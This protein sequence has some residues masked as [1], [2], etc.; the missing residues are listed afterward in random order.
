[1]T[2]LNYCP[3]Y[4]CLI[5]STTTLLSM[6]VAGSALTYSF[7]HR[8]RMNFLFD[9]FSFIIQCF[10][11]YLLSLTK[12]PQFKNI[13]SPF[14]F[15]ILHKPFLIFALLSFSGF[16]LTLL[17]SLNSGFVH[18]ITEHR[19]S[20]S[21]DY[22][23]CRKAE[24]LQADNIR[25]TELNLRMKNYGEEM[26]A[27]IKQNEILKAKEEIHNG[28]NKLL[29]IS[30]KA[31]ESGNITDIENALSLWHQDALLLCREAGNNLN[32]NAMQNITSLADTLDLKLVYD[33]EPN[34][35]DEQTA[36]LFVKAACEAM[37]NAVKH[38]NADS[39]EISITETGFSF[40]NNGDLP[41]EGISFGGGLS[42]IKA[43]ADNSEYEMTV[44]CDERFT[45]IFRKKENNGI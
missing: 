26:Q 21:D 14:M 41:N 19:K 22:L 10:V 28:M 13:I 17:S 11:L 32:R 44:K 12:G 15:S 45:L 2:S 38:A 35:D 20:L 4:I 3:Y 5:F 30:S 18:S 16:L 33:K 9:L 25:L 7:F 27:Q 40:S 42:T 34:I 39:F 43:L 36:E 6:I 31:I 24:Q 23:L 37:V 8:K 29:M 1:M